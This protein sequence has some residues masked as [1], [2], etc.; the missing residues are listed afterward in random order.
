MPEGIKTQT[1]AL[2]YLKQGHFG[3]AAAVFAEL[4]ETDPTSRTLQEGLAQSREALANQKGLDMGI[5]DKRLSVLQGFLKKLLLVPMVAVATP[6][7][8]ASPPV[9]APEPEAQPEPVVSRSR[10]RLEV[11]QQLLQQLQQS[12]VG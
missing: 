12:H 11:L 8:V 5:N 9:W 2:L 10:S 6:T 4:L 3:R 7:L 1:L